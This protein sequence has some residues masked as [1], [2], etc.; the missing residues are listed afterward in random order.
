M[1]RFEIETPQGRFEVE[2]PSLQQA[3]AVLGGGE[4]TTADVSRQFTQSEVLEEDYA[5][6][7]AERRRAR[8]AK[9]DQAAYDALP[10]WKKPLAAG[11][12]ILATFANGATF[13][14]GDKAVA[15]ARSLFGDKS[16]D[17]ELAGQRRLTEAARNRAGYAGTAAELAGGVGSAVKLARNG[18]TLMRGGQSL[19]RLMAGGAAEGAGYGALT[20]LGNDTDVGTSALAG[21]IIGGLAPG[22]IEVLRKT[23]A[24]LFARL[25]PEV[26]TD[27]AI[28]A[29]VERS[30]R[31]PQQVVSD[32]NAAAVEGQG[33][34]MMADA[35]GNPG[36]RMLSTI[37]RTPNNARGRVI[38]EL[39][40]RQAGQG[41]RVAGFIEEGFG[42]PLTAAQTEAARTAARRAS[43]NVNY[44][45]A[46][47]QAGPVNVSQAIQ[48]IDNVV[49]PGV[50]AQ[51]GT[52]A[53]NNSVYSAMTRM[54]AL[55]GN[56]RGQVTDFSR[57]LLAKQEMDALIEQ[58][59][60]V[61]AL[62]RPARNAL[63]AA[64]EHASAPYAGA[65]DAYRRAS[66]GIEAV[67]VG[68]QAARRGRFEDTIPRFRGMSPDEQAGFR[69]GYADPLI[70]RAQMGATGVNKARPLLTD[71]TSQEFPAFAQRGRAPRLDR[72]LR[73]EMRMFE[74][75]N[76]ATGGSRTADNLADQADM[77]G[78]DP[79]FW[80]NLISGN[81]A[82]AAGSAGR[83]VIANINGL[84]PA[85]R[86]RL[87]DF[88]L[89]RNATPAME[90][91][92]RAVATGQRISRRDLAT[93]RLLT[94]IAVGGSVQAQ[95]RLRGQ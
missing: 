78:Y 21:G 67:D 6:A 59:G 94:G 5:T 35:L 89:T 18:L 77:G 50:T 1:P 37:T 48:A 23:F 61:A 90:R 26:A 7:I 3:I 54:R 63:D 75:R 65:R 92:A 72:Q 13:G 34:F 9:D 88:L 24:P 47:V 83:Q 74:T 95:R 17:E 39:D 68:R 31:T 85:V 10:G 19:P 91:I 28:T 55:L 82:G 76:Q 30:G 71:K 60:T 73:R 12:D 56:G 44:G 40:R 49:A 20:A 33:E 87:A 80:T 11:Q 93:I 46:R 58:G 29:M 41:E 81:V 43:G 84:P 14:F 51:L 4:P 70:E 69:A 66:Q 32:L 36:Q 25:R 22:A 79:A 45:N 42:R 86:E 16:Y 15:G 52:S 27:R 64:L 38:E 2:A 62:L 53:A 57:A 8:R